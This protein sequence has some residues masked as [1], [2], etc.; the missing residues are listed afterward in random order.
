MRC[1]W[2]I[3]EDD[4]CGPE[5]CDDD[6][7]VV[8]G[9]EDDG[10]SSAFAGSAPIEVLVVLETRHEESQMMRTKMP[11]SSFAGDP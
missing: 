1:S 6:R 4:N 7:R 9:E 3:V 2:G 10:G 5:T 8:D 11:G